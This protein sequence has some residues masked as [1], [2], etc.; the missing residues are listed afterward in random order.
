MDESMTPIQVAQIV[1]KQCYD[2]AQK[3]ISEE[4]DALNRREI[5]TYNMLVKQHESS[6]LS[7]IEKE[8]LCVLSLIIVQA[9]N[10]TGG[11]A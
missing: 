10:E 9:K 11:D 8:V 1:L 5:E 2:Q 6:R 4:V 7:R 3:E